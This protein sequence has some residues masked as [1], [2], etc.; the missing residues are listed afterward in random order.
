MIVPTILENNTTEI[1]KKLSLID[2]VAQLIQIDLITDIDGLENLTTETKLQLHFMI[3]EVDKYLENKIPNV[4]SVCT[5]VETTKDMLLFLTKSR[6]HG[7]RAGV[8]VAPDTPS[9]ILTSFVRQ[10]DYVQFMTVKVGKQGQPFEYNV[11]NKIKSFRAKYP[12]IKIHADG[13]ISEKTIALFKGMKI[14]HFVVGSAIFGS[15]NPVDSYTKLS[16]YE[17]L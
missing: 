5:E 15:E 4:V 8:S 2:K 1:Q 10:V 6:K 16:T 13:G 12:N 11:L 9:E 14:D 7:Y 3:P 17:K